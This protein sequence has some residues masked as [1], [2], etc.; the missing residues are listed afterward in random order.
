[1]TR[2]DV[3]T[4]VEFD[5]FLRAFEAAAPS[6]DPVPM[7]R[8]VDS[9]GTWDEVRAKVPDPR[10]GHRGR[11]EA[12]RSLGKWNLAG[13]GESCP[14]WREPAKAYGHDR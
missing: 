5:E 2:V 14:P 12:R 6:F 8:I 4:G 3:L 10:A 7:Q 9:G 1:M 13:N 11:S